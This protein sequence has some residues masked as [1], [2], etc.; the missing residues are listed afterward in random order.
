MTSKQILIVEDDINAATVLTRILK[1]EGYAAEPVHTA[2][3]ALSLINEIDYD[4]LIIDMVLPGKDG[5]WLLKKAKELNP[6]LLT[7]IVTAYGS[8]TS[9]VKALKAGANDFLEKPI[10]PEKLLH[11]LRKNFEERRL[12]NEVAALRS[13]LVQRY[14]FA[15]IIGKHPKMLKIYQLIESVLD[16]DSAVLIT[17]ETGTGKDL[18]ARAIHFQSRRQQRPFAAI[19]CASLP[20]NLLESE[21]FGYER[22]AFTGAQKRKIGKLEQADGGTVFLDEIGDMP[23]AVQAKLLRAIQ[24]K[25]IERLGSTDAVSLDIRIISATNK[26]ISA[27][28]TRN[29]FRLDLFYRLNVVP[30][31]IPPLRERI[32]DIPLL[33]D[34][35]LNKLAQKKGGPVPRVTE[36]VLSRLVAHSWPGNVRELENVLERALIMNPGPVIEDV[37][38]ANVNVRTDVSQSSSLPEIDMSLPLKAVR[39]QIVSSL[40]REY[41]ENLLKKYQGSIKKTSAHAHIDTRTVRRKMREFGLDK[42]DFKQ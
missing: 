12:R 21:L 10:L 35:F 32:E 17:G 19:N 22:G 24:T 15:N 33:L 31:T 8:I 41:L 27:E 23:M 18:V 28:I 1:K 13:D 39:D 2:E 36:N 16:T 26:N 42:W 7:L 5:M 11:V 40:E 9:A 38:F 34:H 30:I 25:K 14:K 29:Q 4:L 3:D 37:L 6:S 20:E